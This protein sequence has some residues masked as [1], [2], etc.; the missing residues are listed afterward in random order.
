MWT[1][2]ETCSKCM[3]VFSSMFKSQWKS[4]LSA[5]LVICR[6][7]RESTESVLNTFW[8]RRCRRNCWWSMEV[9]INSKSWVT[10]SK[11][12]NWRP[13]S[14]TQRIQ[15]MSSRPTQP[16]NMCISTHHYKNHLPLRKF[17]RLRVLMCAGYKQG[18]VP[19]VKIRF[20]NCIKFK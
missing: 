14:S 9:A 7:K 12:I 8:F 10:L 20:K 13:K 3:A 18:S 11:L 5:R 19:Q 6:M 16:K 4:I 15:S 1:G 2:L 17:S